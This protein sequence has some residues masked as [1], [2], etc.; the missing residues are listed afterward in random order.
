MAFT[1][2]HPWGNRARDTY[3]AERLSVRYLYFYPGVLPE[4]GAVS[5]DDTPPEAK[6]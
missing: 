2:K 4:T 3:F 6:A 1:W 5:P